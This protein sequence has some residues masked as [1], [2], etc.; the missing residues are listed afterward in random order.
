MDGEMDYGQE[1][2][3]QAGES[4]EAGSLTSVEPLGRPELER[5][6]LSRLERFATLLADPMVRDVPAWHR[7]TRHA[8]AA[9][10][11]DCASLA[12]KEQASAIIEVAFAERV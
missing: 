8:L 11:R 7:L 2:T 10:Y 6:A 1:Q 3:G 9:A 4:V 5:L 12:L